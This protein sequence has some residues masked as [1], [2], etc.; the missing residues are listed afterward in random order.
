MKTILVVDDEWALVENL[1]ELFEYE[2]Y[3]V[4]SATNG[5]DGIARALEEKPDLVLT[6]FMMPIA[7]GCALVL[8]LRAIPE[9]E[10][11]PIVMMSATLREVALS[12][13]R[14][15]WLPVTAFVSKPMSWNVLLGVV[16]PLLAAGP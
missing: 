10:K 2:G 16:A 7:D 5:N 4:V 11:I 14:G 8:G 6:D 1:I 12:D 15:D 13:P 3:R 9:F